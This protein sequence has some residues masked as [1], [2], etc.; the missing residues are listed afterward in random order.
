MQED[1]FGNMNRNTGGKTMKEKTKIE[2][3]KG[4]KEEVKEPK[5]MDVTCIKRHLNDEYKRAIE[6][7]EVITLSTKYAKY[8][9]STGLVK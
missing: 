5:T 2:E 6:E 3:V 8:L 7:G 9:I 1:M 4:N